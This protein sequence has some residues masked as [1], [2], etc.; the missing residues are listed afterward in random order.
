LLPLILGRLRTRRRCRRRPPIY[1]KPRRSLGKR[2]SWDQDVASCPSATDEPDPASL[3][4][5]ME[6]PITATLGPV[7]PL[8]RKLHSIGPQQCPQ[9]QIRLLKVLCISLKDLS[10]DED[11]SCT[12][13]W[14]IKITRELCYDLEDHL[15]EVS[16]VRAH[17]HY[18][19]LLHRVIDASE[20]HQRF[21]WS[22][23]K[24]IKPATSRPTSPELPVP[25]AAVETSMTMI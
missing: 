16:G 11:L 22:P 3:Q 9:D 2:S 21:Q 25:S 1:D 14:W 12:T 8:L 23:P 18:S 6:V 10:E 13:Q 24:T 15:D 19:E 7:G 17:H 5:A 4:A 20:R